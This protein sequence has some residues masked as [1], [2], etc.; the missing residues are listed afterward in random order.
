MTLQEALAKC[1]DLKPNQYETLQKIEW[2][3]E[4]ESKIWTEIIRNRVQETDEEGKPP[5]SYTGYTEA[6]MNTKLLAQMY[7]ELYIYYLMSK[8]D[9]FNGETSRYNTSMAMFN[10]AYQGFSDYW[11]RTHRSNRAAVPRNL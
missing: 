9:F 6:D 4:L 8:I 11:Y 3:N 7:S 2:I 5:L 10:Q 1:D